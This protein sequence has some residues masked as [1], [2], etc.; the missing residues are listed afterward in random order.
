MKIAI[1]D[2]NKKVIKFLVFLFIIG[3]IL[4]ML[5]FLSKTSEEKLNIA[6]SILDIK[7]NIINSK[8]N[9][10]LIHFIIISILSILSFCLIGLPL[11]L[12]YYFYEGFSIG[13]LICTFIKCFS[14]KGF[15]FSAIFLVINK[16]I[17]LSIFT[18]FLFFCISYVNKF[19]KNIK[20]NK[21]VIIYNHLIKC[22]FVLFT[23][24]INDLVLYFLG[25]NILSLFTFLI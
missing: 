24:F 21:Q 3:I 1:I 4:G 10:I 17:F 13:F 22:L 14:V 18:Y 5:L 19:I 2:R 16:F 8:Q 9:S 15:V 6:N 12:F 25:N 23:V 11:A 20:G 7:N